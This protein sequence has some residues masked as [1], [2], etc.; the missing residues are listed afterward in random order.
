[1]PSRGP[2]VR[3]SLQVSTKPVNT[4]ATIASRTGYV[5]HG[6][7]HETPFS[8]LGS[9]NAAKDDQLQLNIE[10]LTA[11]KIFVIEQLA[12]KN[13]DFI[14]VLQGTHCTTADKPV[15]PNFSVAGS[16]L[17]GHSGIAT[18]PMSGWNGHWSISLQNNQRLSGCAYTLPDVRS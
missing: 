2:P 9:W 4:R 17:S 12:D 10:G 11:D 18:L 14:I 7:G 1:M 6:V 8:R 15:I 3:H 16:V 13:K 5:R